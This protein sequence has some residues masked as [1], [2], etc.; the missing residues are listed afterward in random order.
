MTLP[1]S[2]FLRS[3]G[4]PPAWCGCACAAMASIR[5]AISS[6]ASR[7]CSVCLRLMFGA[8]WPPAVAGQT[9]VR[10][11]PVGDGVA[12]GGQDDGGV[13]G[14]HVSGAAQRGPVAIIQ[15]FAAP[16]AAG[17]HGAA[18]LGTGS[19]IEP[20]VAGVA[21]A[22]RAGGHRPAGAGKQTG[23]LGGEQA[24]E[25][26]LL[27]VAEPGDG[28]VV[29]AQAGQ[30]ARLGLLEQV[31]VGRGVQRGEARLAFRQA[32]ARISAGASVPGPTRSWAYSSR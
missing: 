10:R 31:P 22:S 29:G 24:H 30:P 17:V 11:S 13:R 20:V 8:G 21:T 27:G 18:W 25:Q 5:R 23:D 12:E 6:T 4:G 32:V 2:A 9:V 26:L 3:A 14:E 16:G 1:S 19:A 7:Y 28:Q 15:C